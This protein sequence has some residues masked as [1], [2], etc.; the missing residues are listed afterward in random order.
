MKLFRGFLIVFAVAMVYGGFATQTADAQ[1][2]IVRTG[3]VVTRPVFVRRVFVRDPF[4]R[5]RFWGYQF[6]YDHYFYDPYLS[7]QR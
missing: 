1:R 7:A 5:D 3:T 4:W 2:R 6:G